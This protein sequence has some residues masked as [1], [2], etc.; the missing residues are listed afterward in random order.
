VNSNIILDP[1]AVAACPVRRG[2]VKYRPVNATYLVFLCSAQKLAFL[3]SYD[4]DECLFGDER[5]GAR[6]LLAASATSLPPPPPV[7]NTNQYRR[8]KQTAYSSEYPDIC[9]Y[10]EKAVMREQCQWGPYYS[11]R[12][13][14]ARQCLLCLSLRGRPHDDNSFFPGFVYHHGSGCINSGYGWE[15]PLD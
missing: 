14:D 8:G 6:R 15:S 12:P 3:I 5:A 7:I 11:L 13:L 1:W 4:S 2:P 9:K 10:T